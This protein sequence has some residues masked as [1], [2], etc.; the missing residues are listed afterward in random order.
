MIFLCIYLF[1]P[2]YAPSR[3]SQ[4]ILKH[5]QAKVRKVRIKLII[6]LVI[7]ILKKH[8]L[9]TNCKN[10]IAKNI[11]NLNQDSNLRKPL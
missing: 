4:G 3:S 8:L 1:P 9:E 7:M 2:N 5:S 10:F 11:L 6:N